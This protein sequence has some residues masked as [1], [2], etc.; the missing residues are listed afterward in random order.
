MMGARRAVKFF[1][2]MHS[3]TQG[4]ERNSLMPWVSKKNWGGKLKRSRSSIVKKNQKRDS[5][6]V[7][8]VRT[9]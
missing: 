5:V 4:D 2:I 1:V 6:G 7:S 8:V 9:T 3:W